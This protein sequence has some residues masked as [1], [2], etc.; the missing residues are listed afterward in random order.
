MSNEFE[1]AKF[2]RR[3]WAVFAKTSRT[4]S[5]IGRGKKFCEKKVKELNENK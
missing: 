2:D 4:F 3:K 1:A 5:H